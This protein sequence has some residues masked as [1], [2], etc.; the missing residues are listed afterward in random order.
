MKRPVKQHVRRT[1]TGRKCKVRAHRRN[2]AGFVILNSKGKRVRDKEGELTPF[3][4]WNNQA[5]KFVMKN[6]D[7]RETLGGTR[8]HKVREHKNFGAL[9]HGTS[10]DRLARMPLTGG[11]QPREGKLYL[12]DDKQY[13]RFRA[14]QAS[15]NT[16]FKGVVIEVDDVKDKKREG[17]HFTTREAIPTEKFK[18]VN[19]V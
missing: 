3:F 19:V 15:E 8:I 16:P 6:K 11:L 10:E 18:R 4:E 12:T 5:K 17:R 1:R 2:Y 9:F 14:R 13:A 7:V